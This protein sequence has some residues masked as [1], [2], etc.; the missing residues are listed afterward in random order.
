MCQ[1][2]IGR[3][4]TSA[5]PDPE[6]HGGRS[7]QWRSPEVILRPILMNTSA[8]SVANDS[9]SFRAL[10]PTRSSITPD[11]AETCDGLLGVEW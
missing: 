8:R 6:R 5:F 1:L 3:R 2:R 10:K 7:L 4:I 9:S 11:A